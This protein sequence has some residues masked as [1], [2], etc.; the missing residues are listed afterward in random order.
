MSD[1][2]SVKG[3]QPHKMSFE[4]AEMNFKKIANAHESKNVQKEN[5]IDE[6][7]FGILDSNG[8]GKINTDD[9]I[10]GKILDTIKDEGV[11]EE[12]PT[13]DIEEAKPADETEETD[14]AQTKSISDMTTEEIENIPAE[15]L[16]DMFLEEKENNTPIVKVKGEDRHMDWNHIYSNSTFFE[17][18]N[19]MSDEKLEEFMNT[20]A[21][22]FPE[23]YESMGERCMWGNYVAYSGIMTKDEVYDALE[24]LAKYYP[25]L[26]YGGDIVQYL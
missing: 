16:I 23:Q 13:E 19:K 7:I 5:A 14:K 15:D 9:E 25:R 3:S 12:N 11:E 10:I 6:N 21:E 26:E 17:Y 1:N 2:F 22:K 20:Y 18:V 4:V 8:D 24:K